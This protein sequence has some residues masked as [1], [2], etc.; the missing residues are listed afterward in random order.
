[1]YCEGCK[2]RFLGKTA[3]MFIGWGWWVGWSS[4][5]LDSWMRQETTNLCTQTFSHWP[6]EKDLL[7][8]SGK[9]STHFLCFACRVII[10][11]ENF[12]YIYIAP[13]P[14]ILISVCFPGWIT[15]FDGPWA[16]CNVRL[17]G[18]GSKALGIILYQPEMRFA[19]FSAWRR[20]VKEKAKWHLIMKNVQLDVLSSKQDFYSSIPPPPEWPLF[21]RSYPTHITYWSSSSSRL[22]WLVSI[23][24][25]PINRKQRKKK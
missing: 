25:P 16:F 7:C 14:K 22:S 6:P 9:F 18:M 4:I 12:I 3:D 2:E 8:H 1:M 24:V 20:G 13:S 10:Y 15:A 23:W 19:A 17:G 11:G 21:F 5:R